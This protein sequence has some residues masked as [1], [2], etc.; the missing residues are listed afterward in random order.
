MGGSGIGLAFSKKYVEMHKGKIGA[1]SNKNGV[2]ATFYFELPLNQHQ[3]NN[4]VTIK[5]QCNELTDNENDSSYSQYK[6]IPRFNTSKLSLLVVEDNPE[7]LIFL[8]QNFRD[9]FHTVLTAT[10]GVNALE[11]IRSMQP[12]II[13]SD[14]VMPRMDGFDLCRIVKSDISISHIPVVL[15]TAR[16]GS[17][18]TLLGYKLGADAYVT[19]PFDIDFLQTILENQLNAREQIRVQYKSKAT[20]MQPHEITF[21]N[22]DEHFITKLNALIENI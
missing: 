21:S 16:T 22:A 9:T 7:L 14:V 6:A 17:E 1:Q 10:N 4:D 3:L 11:I 18:D 20:V 12:D 2:G 13:L 8:K 15:L 5:A 19:K